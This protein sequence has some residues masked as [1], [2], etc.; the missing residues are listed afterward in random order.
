MRAHDGQLHFSVDR[1][2]LDQVMS[3]LSGLGIEELTVSPASLEDMFLS[4]YH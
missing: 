1:D 3:D 2:N 4:E